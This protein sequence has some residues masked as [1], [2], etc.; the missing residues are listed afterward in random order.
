MDKSPLIFLAIVGLAISSVAQSPPPPPT[1]SKAGQDI[2]EERSAKDAKAANAGSPSKE[3]PSVV[4]KAT[5]K[6][7]K[8]NANN[9]SET[10]S[11]ETP[12]NWGAI[13]TGLL[14]LFNLL[15][16]GVGFLQW[17]SIHK[18]AN[19]MR[20]N[21]RA[22]VGIDRILAPAIAANLPYRPQV[23]MKN[24]GQTYA[25]HLHVACT[26]EP[27]DRN[28]ADEY[29]FDFVR[30][31]QA[32]QNPRRSDAL[33]PPNNYFKLRVNPLRRGEL[34]TEEMFHAFANEQL[35]MFVYGKACYVDIFEQ[36]HWTKFC[37]S[38][39]TG[40]EMSVFLPYRKHN[41]MDEST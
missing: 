21:Q 19:Y 20:V 5:A 8:K 30:I 4:E 15:L 7:Q 14:T 25:K 3:A 11:K 10:D 22:W 16:V 36:H 6:G 12:T 41:E 2:Q 39:Q 29:V 37:F 9:K 38:L 17:R 40:E 13:N 28:D 34:V 32:L 35:I 31:E 23:L 1:P 27:F 33:L 24:S 18:Q 26:C